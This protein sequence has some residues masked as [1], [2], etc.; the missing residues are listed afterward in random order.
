[1]NE[2]QSCQLLA[3]VI[4]LLHALFVAFVVLGFVLVVIG[5]LK[6]WGWV[7]N[8][9]FRLAHL[10]AIGVVVAQAWA[11]Q[12]CPLTVWESRL[13]VAAGGVGYS[14]SFIQH[15]VHK[16]LF[17]NVPLWVCAVVYTVFGLAVLASWV[18]CPP[19][20]GSGRRTADPG[21]GG[22]GRSP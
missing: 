6:R 19:R 17:F 12:Y 18:F 9:W 2:G 11:G 1:M 5:W 14:Q 7:R 13:R 16:L 10:L 22:A 4:L 8:L 21:A 20:I 3:D 15:W